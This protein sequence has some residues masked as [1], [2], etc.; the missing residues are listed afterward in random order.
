MMKIQRQKCQPMQNAYFCLYFQYSK[1][2]MH[3]MINNLLMGEID[4]P[5]IKRVEPVRGC[6]ITQAV[7]NGPP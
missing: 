7:W 5:S 4:R 1:K 3:G 6:L 2:K